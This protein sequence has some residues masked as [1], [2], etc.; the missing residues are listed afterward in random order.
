MVGLS[1]CTL[2][3][4]KQFNSTPSLEFVELVFLDIGSPMGLVI[5]EDIASAGE[6]I[7]AVVD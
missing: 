2:N 6:R 5:V 1:P 3:T 7:E 4:E